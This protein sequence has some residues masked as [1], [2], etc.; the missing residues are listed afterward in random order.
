VLKLAKL[1]YNKISLV[2]QTSG[3]NLAN[4][5]NVEFLQKLCKYK[6]LFIVDIKAVSAGLHK[7]ITQTIPTSYELATIEF[8]EKAKV[9][10]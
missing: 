6:P 3:C 7:K 5:A 10:F 1:C 8:L 2:I 4:K 9:D